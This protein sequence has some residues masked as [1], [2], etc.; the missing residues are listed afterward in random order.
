MRKRWIGF[1]IFVLMVVGFVTA[2]GQSEGD[3]PE[4]VEL[5]YMLWDAN[6]QAAYEAVAARFTE[7]NPSIQI[8]ITQMGWDDYW[9]DIPRRMAIGDGPDVFTNHLAFVNDFARR[10]Q[11]VDIQS[12][13]ERDRVDIEQY[14]PGLA[15]LWTRDGKRWGLPKDWD[16]IA[17]VVNAEMFEAAGLSLDELTSW[18]WNPGDGG[19]FG[20]AMRQVTAATGTYALAA[21]YDSGFGQQEWS[22]FAHSTGWVYTPGPFSGV[23]NYDDPRLHEVVRWFQ[24]MIGDGVFAPLED[25][26]GIGDATLFTSQRIA[27]VPAGSWMI[28]HYVNNA[29]FPIRFLPLPTG[30]MGQRSPFNGLADSIWVGTEHLEEA[31]KWVA[32]LGSEEAQSIVGR[33]GVVFPAVR[34]TEQ[35]T[36]DEYASRGVDVT[37]FTDLV[38]EP[39]KTFLFPLT[40]NAAEVQE[41]FGDALEEAYLSGDDPASILT[42]ANDR[43]NGL[44]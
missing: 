35:L 29:E 16:T 31:W 19:S 11:V 43:V 17:L 24:G 36:I 3:S 25:V 6:Q 28:G 42:A 5:E 32:F 12:F 21:L 13:V 44:F 39:G 10:G 2:E 27:A 8:R 26:G 30:P 34:G 14:Y 18:D 37:A 38:Q 7:L 20:E 40:D 23:F 41:I 22:H 4:G 33:A 9:T 1:V 15:D